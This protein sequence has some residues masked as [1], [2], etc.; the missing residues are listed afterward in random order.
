M[1]RAFETF[2]QVLVVNDV[3][4][5][6]VVAV[7]PVHAADSLEQAVVLHLLVNVEEGR[8]G[9]IEAGQ[10]FVHDDDQLQL[11]RLLDE[12]LFHRQLE[13]F[14]LFDGFLRWLVKPIRQHLFVDVVLP[15]FFRQPLAAFFAFDGRRGW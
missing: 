2:E 8:R 1:H 6:L 12:F 9:R 5:I 3:A 4:V 14:N 7:Q 13:F 11:V 10:Q 15:Q